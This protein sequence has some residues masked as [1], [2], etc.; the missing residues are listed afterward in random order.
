MH[1]KGEMSIFPDPL[2]F[3]FPARYNRNYLVL[4]VQDTYNLYAYWEVTPERLLITADYLQQ[5]P[6][7]LSLAIRLLQKGKKGSVEVTRYPVTDPCGQRYF[8]EFSAN[9]V[10]YAEIGVLQSEGEFLALLSSEQVI[11]PVVEGEL[12]SRPKDSLPMFP[13][14]FFQRS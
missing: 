12:E 9:K 5:S 1:G 2:N 11:H 13:P 10:Y 7:N 8:S 3:S 14:T 4:L 6:E